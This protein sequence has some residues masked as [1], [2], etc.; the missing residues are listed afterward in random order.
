MSQK[1]KTW[2]FL[3]P[4]LV[5]AGVLVMLYGRLGKPTDVQM[6]TALERSVPTF[7]LPMLSD[8]SIILTN[9][10]LP[11]E[12]Y[13]LNVWGSWCPTCV[14]EHPMLMQ[15]SQQ[16]VTMVGVNYRDDLSDALGYLNDHGDPFVLSIQDGDGTLALDLGLTGAPETFVVDS[17]GII[18]QHILGEVAKA[19]WSARIQPCLQALQTKA[20]NLH[21]VCQ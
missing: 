11:K 21:E 4:L 5:F 10:Q 19:N 6:N 12:P 14:A 13:L 7:S 16:G 3:L 17:D 1:N 20:N 18:R 2:L 9:E 15:L 8:T